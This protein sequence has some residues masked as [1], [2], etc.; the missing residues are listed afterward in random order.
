[1]KL[2]N[3][4]INTAVGI[5]ENQFKIVLSLYEGNIKDIERVCAP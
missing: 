4:A 5:I 1:M 3:N 2:G